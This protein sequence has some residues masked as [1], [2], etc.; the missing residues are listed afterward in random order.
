MKF[1]KINYISNLDDKI[2]AIFNI[3]NIN[4]L[5]C[6]RFIK[7]GKHHNPKN[8][9]YVNSRGYKEFRLNNIYYGYANGYA[10]DFTKLS[11]RKFIKLLAFL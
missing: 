10:K 11:W 2:T 8:A 3:L 4:S 9:A 1:Y 7:N 5:H 6:V